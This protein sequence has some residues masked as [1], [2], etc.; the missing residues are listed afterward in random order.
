MTDDTRRVL[1][2]FIKGHSTSFPI[3]AP[4]NATIHQVKGLVWEQGK[5]SVFQRTDAREI[6]LSKVSSEWLADSYQLIPYS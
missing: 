1:W 5:N 4:G 3:A 6:E 2:C